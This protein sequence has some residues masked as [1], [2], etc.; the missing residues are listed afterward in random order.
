MASRSKFVAEG[1]GG[2]DDAFRMRV[3]SHYA[4]AAQAKKN[5]F[6]IHVGMGVFYILVIAI[7]L[8]PHTDFQPHWILYCGTVLPFLGEFAKG[9][10]NA[11][12][13]HAYTFLALGIGC[14]LLLGIGHFVTV[15]TTHPDA[16]PFALIGMTLL[17]IFGVAAHLAAVYTTRTIIS[18]NVG[19]SR[20]KN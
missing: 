12:L 18:T 16:N 6:P 15:F 11:L 4:A 20:K 3:A 19:H 17:F 2:T 9:K 7:V 5:L 10:S 8:L 14:F 13:L 1:C